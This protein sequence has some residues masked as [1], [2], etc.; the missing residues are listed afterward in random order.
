MPADEKKDGAVAIPVTAGKEPEKKDKKKN[1]PEELSEEDQAL[2][3]GLE[4]AVT[5]LI[6]SDQSLHKQALDYLCSEIRSSTASM[7]SVPK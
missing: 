4:L 2:K 3:E 6:E 7:T 1:D 5:R